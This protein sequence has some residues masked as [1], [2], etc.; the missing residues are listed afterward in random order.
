MENQLTNSQSHFWQREAHF[1]SEKLIFVGVL[2][3]TR[4]S[5]TEHLE[6]DHVPLQNNFYHRELT[7][8]LSK[9]QSKMFQNSRQR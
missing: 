5:L 4:R 6:I 7:T 8:H 3:S 1:R 9:R 2:N